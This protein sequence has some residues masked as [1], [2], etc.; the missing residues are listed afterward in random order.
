MAMM[1]F[2]T[3]RAT[4]AS[5]VVVDVFSHSS[6][7]EVMFKSDESNWLDHRCS[8]RLKPSRAQPHNSLTAREI[9]PPFVVVQKQAEQWAELHVAFCLHIARLRIS[10]SAAQHSTDTRP[11]R[12]REVRRKKKNLER[13]ERALLHLCNSG[14][15]L[16]GYIHTSDDATM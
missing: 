1:L 16:S 15:D 6:G 7:Q 13:R 2:T 9:S 4:A 11:Q 14:L 5:M 12:K 3:P 10:C 8:L